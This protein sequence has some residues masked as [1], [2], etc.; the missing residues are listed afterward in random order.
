MDSQKQFDFP[1]AAKLR[2]LERVTCAGGAHVKSL[3]KALDGFA[4]D[5]E[6]CTE[7]L[8]RISV[9]MGVSVSTAKRA[10]VAAEELGL[11]TVYGDPTD[12][13]SNT[14]KINW[15]TVFN[16]PDGLQ[17][18]PRS[19]TSPTPVKMTWDPVQPDLGPRSTWTGT[20]VKMN[21]VSTTDRNDQ[22]NATVRPAKS[23]GE[24]GGFL[25]CS[26]EPSTSRPKGWWAWSFDRTDLKNPAEMVRLFKSAVSAG[27][28]EDTPIDRVRFVALT[29]HTFG[30]E[31]I[32][33]PCGYVV[34][35]VERGSWNYLSRESVKRALSLL[36]GDGLTLTPDQIIQVRQPKSN[37]IPKD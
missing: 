34:T 2:A 11:L 8:R 28:I 22:V 37:A 7:T 27:V 32:R 30:Q 6:T 10:R 16:L 36:A 3:L 21:G 15:Q 19:K 29:L 13:R 24:E 31:N 4:R 9:S 33:N 12:G 26:F 14:Y 25:D 5:A 1:R 23:D 18:R 20:P 17:I 35:H